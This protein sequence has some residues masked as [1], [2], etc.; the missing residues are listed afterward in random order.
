MRRTP[1]TG[2][3]H[4]QAAAACFLGVGDQ[5]VGRAVGGDDGH[6]EGHVEVLEDLCRLLHARQVGVR[7]HNHSHYRQS[8]RVGL[9]FP[10]EQAH[11]PQHVRHGVASH[12]DV[13]HLALRPGLCLAVPVERGARQAE[14]PLHR[15]CAATHR[16]ALAVVRPADQV[17]HGGSAHF[18][19]GRAERHAQHSAYVVLELVAGAG[20]LCVVT[21]V[22]HARSH[23]VEKDLSGR[24]HEKFHAEDSAPRQSSHNR[25]CDAGRL[26]LHCRPAHTR[27]Q[28]TVGRRHGGVAH[29][30]PLHG[31]HDGVGRQPAV[32]RAR[33]NARELPLEGHPALG[34]HLHVARRPCAER[35]ERLARA[36]AVRDDGVAAAVVGIALGLEHQR[37][38]PVGAA[39]QHAFLVLHLPEVAHWHA[40]D[41]GEVHLL[42]V[43]VLDDPQ[44]RRR[45]LNA[46]RRVALGDRVERVHVGVLD[47]VRHHLAARGHLLERLGVL[48][49][50]MD[51]RARNLP[52]GGLDAKWVDDHGLD[53]E[54][55]RSE[56]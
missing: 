9:P 43:L 39:A 2:N 37:E 35:L 23:L 31:V 8:R 42:R 46:E 5:P 32:G 7:A 10:L 34:V 54:P 15:S 47:L 41:G 17:Q 25:L 24:R 22:V 38:A 11:C 21:R 28:L 27:R 51:G 45:R 4:L 19:C 50:A 6:L 56:A 44:R 29:R 30:E 1:R 55:V 49:R 52:G 13:P 18:E 40:T 12:V 33:D 20:V 3:D 53:A 16:A 26:G 14:R 36:R 48:D